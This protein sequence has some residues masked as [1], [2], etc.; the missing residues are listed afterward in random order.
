GA[1]CCRRD[2]G[3]AGARDAADTTGRLTLS[4]TCL[5]LDRGRR[6]GRPRGRYAGIE[7]EQVPVPV[8]LAADVRYC[9]AHAHSRRPA[10][11][12]LVERRALPA[13]WRRARSRRN[14]QADTVQFAQAALAAASR[15][16]CNWR[17][18]RAMLRSP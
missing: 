14:T 15:R 6:V 16:A 3:R 13:A 4:S 2:D 1:L 11:T 7:S 10:V 12:T 9:A 8:N 5:R 17:C 18:G